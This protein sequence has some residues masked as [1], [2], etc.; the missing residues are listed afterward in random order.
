MEDNSDLSPG[1]MT[2]YFE[3]VD[4]VWVAT[5]DHELCFRRFCD[6]FERTEA[7]GGVVVDS[8]D[9]VLMIFRRNRWDLPKGH[10]EPGESN[11]EASLREAEEE[12]GLKGLQTGSHITD[13]WHFYDTYG[14]WEMKRTR[15]YE[16]RYDGKETPVPQ[17]EEDITV[18]RWMDGA[19][20]QKAGDS[21]YGTVRDVL[22]AAGRIRRSG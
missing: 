19:D 21:S 22:V 12:T 1:A 2:G 20:L 10:V 11:S 5:R 17:Q 9:R 8:Q 4:C 6:G 14:R 15:W 3:R 13:T 18:A 16:M 7:A